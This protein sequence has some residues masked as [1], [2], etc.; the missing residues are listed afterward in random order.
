MGQMGRMGRMIFG[1]QYSVGSLPGRRASVTALHMG[2]IGPIRPICR[3][4][5]QRSA[6]AQSPQ[7]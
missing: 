2:P 4:I 1:V 7:I 6:M 3:H 5:S